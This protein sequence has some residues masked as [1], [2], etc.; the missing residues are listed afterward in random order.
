MID[1][2]HCSGATGARVP[3]C[4]RQK[5]FS[6]LVPEKRLRR[7]TPMQDAGHQALQIVRTATEHTEMI[8]L[9][10]AYTHEQITEKLKID[11]YLYSITYRFQE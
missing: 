2:G 9:T 4:T 8:A 3:F 11:A 5:K 7:P 10:T 1:I 6:V